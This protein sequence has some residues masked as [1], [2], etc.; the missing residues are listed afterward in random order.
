MSLDMN[1]SEHIWDEFGCA[2]RNRNDPPTNLYQLHDALL[3]EWDRIPR[4][5]LENLVACVF[6]AHGGHTQY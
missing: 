5:N 6:A 3:E 4:H 2:M 1:P